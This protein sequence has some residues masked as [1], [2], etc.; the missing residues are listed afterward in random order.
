MFVLMLT[1][2]MLSFTPAGLVDTGDGIEYAYDQG[3]FVMEDAGADLTV[4]LTGGVGANGVR[5]EFDAP[6]TGVSAVQITFRPP[7]DTI[8]PTVILTLPPEATGSDAGAAVLPQAEGVP[9]LMA[10]IWTLEVSVTTSTGTQT[11]QKTFNLE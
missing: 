5:V 10:G 2:W 6:A 1:A 7:D 3:R 8:A 9:L 4:F 11:L